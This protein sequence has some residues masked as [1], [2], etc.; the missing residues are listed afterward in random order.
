MNIFIQDT[1]KLKIYFSDSKD[2][3]MDNN[4]FNGEM[5]TKHAPPERA[6]GRVIN[7]MRNYF[8]NDTLTTHFLN[9]MNTPVVVLNKYRQIVFANEE[10]RLFINNDLQKIIG[11]RVGEVVNCKNAFIEEGGCGTA[12]ACQM[13]GAVNVML[14]GFDGT[15]SV[16]ECRILTNDDD[17]VELMVKGTPLVVNN[18]TYLLFAF[19]DISSEKRRRAL[20][21]IFFHDILNTAGGIKGFIEIL[22]EAEEEEEEEFYSIVKR[23]SNRLI[24]EIE[25]QKELN[26]AENKELQLIISQFDLVDFLE[27]MQGLYLNHTVAIGK[28]IEIDK[29][30]KNMQI[31]TDRRLLGRVIGNMVKNALEASKDDDV[32]T[33]GALYDGESVEIWIHNP[34][35]IPRRN[36]LQIFQRSFSTKGNG[37]GLGTFSMKML[38]ERYLQGRVEFSTHEHSGTIFKGVYP[39]AISE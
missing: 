28:T 30:A 31:R 4:M 22:A 39:V 38:S 6:S 15:Q 32:V 26:A 36:Q 8:E 11:L 37:R 33:I 5:K 7:E 35:Y 2:E 14:K 1:Y 24:D 9:A 29:Y 19:T 23:L 17:A 16:M 21:K 13:C 10:A 18:E 34:G 12:E 20:E 27:E 25:A 3:K